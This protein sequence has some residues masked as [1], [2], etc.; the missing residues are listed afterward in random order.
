M[1]TLQHSS[2]RTFSVHCGRLAQTLPTF[3][4]AHSQALGCESTL[5][6][7]SKDF[8]TTNFFVGAFERDCSEPM[9]TLLSLSVHYY[10]LYV[11]GAAAHARS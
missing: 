3:F 5:N 9:A 7:Y 11:P 8:E 4:P 2:V 6:S 10:F 1:K